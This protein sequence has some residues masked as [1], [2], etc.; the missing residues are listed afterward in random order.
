MH[1]RPPAQFDLQAHRGGSALTVESTLEAFATA[2]ALGVSTLEVGQPGASVWLG[3]TTSTTD[4]D[5]VAAVASFG[6][7]ALSP[8]HGTAQD[9]SVTNAGCT[10][11]T[12]PELVAD[13]HAAGIAVTPW[14]VN[15]R[16]TMQ[17]LIDIDGLI[18]DRPTCCARS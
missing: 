9:G 2:L 1:A 15:D 4:G 5:L 14:T 6:G 12:T 10:P 8:V 16:A 11:Y 18:T 3:G 7:D 17:A 13:A